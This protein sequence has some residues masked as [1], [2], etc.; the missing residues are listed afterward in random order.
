MIVE[1]NI[2]NFAIIDDLKINFE[3]GL[4]VLTGETGAGKSIIIE[5]INM[6]LGQRAN[7]D[8][9]RTGEDKAILEGVF[10]LENP[11]I[12]NQILKENGIDN[13]P[14]NYL[15]ITREIFHNGRTVSRINGRVVTLSILNSITTNLVDIHGQ[16]E[17]QSLLNPITHIKLLDNFGN[18]ELKSMLEIVYKKYKKLQEEKNKLKKLSYDTENIEREIDLLKYQL[19]DIDSADILNLDENEII[20]HYNKLNN[21]KD[22]AYNLGQVVEMLNSDDYT[23]F[24]ILNNLNRCRTVLSSVEK[25]DETLSKYN[26]LLESIEYELRDVYRNIKDYLEK[27]E[28]DEE[29]LMILEE[30]IDLLNSLKRKYGSTIEEIIEYRNSIEDK[31]NSLLN[32]EKIIEEVNREINNLE[33]E[34]TDDCNKLTQ[35]RKSIGQK[36]E[37]DITGE[38]KELNME[39]A[40]FK[41]NFEKYDYFTSNGLDKVEFLISTNKG[42][43]LKPLSKIISGGEM[44]RIMLAFK[45][46]LSNYDNIPTLIFDEIDT[47]ISG[48][49]AQIVGKKF[50]DISRNRQVICISHLPQIAALADV[51]FLISKEVVKDKTNVAVKKLNYDERIDELSRL[52]GGFNLTLTTKL[53]AKEM[54]DMSKSLS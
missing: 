11:S 54:L 13:D 42:E 38:L 8:F 44:S 2:K 25:Y 5:G 52:L 15:I 46:I 41:V 26:N 34:L 47:G 20:S 23:S 6:I 27:L 12:I 35:L 43:D 36:L 7:R 45:R 37:Q 29:E 10:Y 4:N 1:L 33:R 24:S 48:R 3:K 9:I 40:I 17:H 18:I 32:N 14:D 22:I 30:K 19:N 39:N 21:I 28:L 51:H 49:T 53:H 16:H 31:L 50:K